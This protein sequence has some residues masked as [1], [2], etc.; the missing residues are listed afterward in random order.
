MKELNQLDILI[1]TAGMVIKKPFVEISEEEYDS[2]FA[3]NAK[4]AFFVCR[5]Q[6]N[7]WRT[8]GV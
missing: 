7:V 4:A 6:P 2:M 5:K 1:N 8:M 3:I